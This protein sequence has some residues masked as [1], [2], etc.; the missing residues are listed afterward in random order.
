M[1]REPAEQV[2]RRAISYWRLTSAAG[3]VVAAVGGTALVLATEGR[4]W[5]WAAAAL[6]LV[7]AAVAVA[8][9]PGLRYRV[10]RWEVT[11]EA[12]YTRSGWVSRDVRIVPLSRVQTISSHQTALMRPFRIASLQVTT[13]S[14]RGAVTIEGL[15]QDV[16]RE[17]VAEL[18]RDTAVSEGD[19]T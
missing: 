18:T 12:I 9:V 15:D 5:A 2:C 7:V 8:V 19:A 14:S 16:A 1:L 17:T 4:W 3:F 13:A 6:A 11:R 10:H